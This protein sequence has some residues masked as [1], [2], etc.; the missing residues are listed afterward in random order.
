MPWSKPIRKRSGEL[1]RDLSVTAYRYHQ[2]YADDVELKVRLIVVQ[3][4]HRDL[5]P[6]HQQRGHGA[7]RCHLILELHLMS[8]SC[9]CVDDGGDGSCSGRGDFFR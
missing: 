3:E 6:R 2:K 4:M 1:A 9:G 7:Y 5:V 8:G